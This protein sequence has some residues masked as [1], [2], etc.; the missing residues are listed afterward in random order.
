MEKGKPL[1]ILYSAIIVGREIQSNFSITRSYLQSKKFQYSLKIFPQIKSSSHTF[2]ENCFSDGDDGSVPLVLCHMLQR[3]CNHPPLL[4]LSPTFRPTFYDPS[5]LMNWTA[6]L[7]ITR[8][9]TFSIS[10]ALR[11][12]T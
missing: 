11:A 7:S 4:A 12:L 5:G 2:H 6:S 8:L 10:S 3:D 9:H 1:D